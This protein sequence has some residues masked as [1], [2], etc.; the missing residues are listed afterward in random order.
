MAAPLVLLATCAE[1]PDLDDDARVLQRAL[2]E[3]GVVARAAVWTDPAVAWEEADLVVIRSTW[4]YATQRDRFLVWAES[5]AAVTALHNPLAMIGWN[6]DKTYLRQLEAAGVPVVPTHFVEPGDDLGAGDQ[7]GSD[8]ADDP[9]RA[10]H[11]YVGT[12]HVVKP[13]VSAGSVDTHRV[14][15]GDLET[16]RRH[17]RSILDSGRTAM[18]QPYL[19]AIDEHGET[20]LLF[21]DGVFSHA[22]RKDAILTPEHAVA[23]G[24]DGLFAEETMSLREASPAE[25]AVAER[26]LAAIPSHVRGE[27]ATSPPLYARIDLLPSDDGPLLLEL[28]LAEPSFFL[29]HV[30]ASAARTL[31]DAILARISGARRRRSPGAP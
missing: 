29:D 26:V 15:P 10:L 21:F 7:S 14:G 22:L 9:G 23:G 27:G 11:P 2:T 25:V 3:R 30:P 1:V 28:E 4:D 18:V 5:V 8:P 31:A 17:L 12:E 19:H 16:S 13:A 6:T 20:A 24:T